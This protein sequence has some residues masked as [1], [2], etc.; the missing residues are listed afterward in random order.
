MEITKK[1]VLVTGCNGFIGK[2]FI[3]DFSDKYNIIGI[4]KKKSISNKGNFKEYVL[5]ICDTKAVE[6]I[7]IKH[8]VQYIIHTAAEKA[9]IICENHKEEAYESN[10]KATLR[11]VEVAEKH[12][13]KFIFIS[14]D[15]VF[16]GTGSNYSEDAE[17]A[18]INYYGELKIMAEEHLKKI[19]NCAICRT[20]LVFG[21]IPPEQHEYFDSVKMQQE[22]AVQ[23]YIVQQT[24]Y[25]LENKLPINLPGNEFI[26][27]THVKLLAK[28]LD[29][30]IQ[31]DASGILH[32]CGKDHI[33]RYEMGKLVAQ[34]YNLDDRY[35][36]GGDGKNPL[37]PQDVSLDCNYT[38]EQLGFK[39]PSFKEM[40]EVYDCD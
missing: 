23:G 20:A 4:D 25:C 22:L 37:R 8:K 12:H 35:I 38:E 40:L 10:Y 2:T 31:R 9:L 13:A 34:K 5:D 21:T 32:C 16:D 26:S 19:K 24:K 14:S 39:F 27:P 28:Q 6:E 36:N 29:A 11:L 18:A 17:V 7:I 1:T 3:E 30:V 15:Q 33:S